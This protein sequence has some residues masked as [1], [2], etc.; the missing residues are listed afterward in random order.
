MGFACIYG[1][2]STGVFITRVKIKQMHMVMRALIDHFVQL[3]ILKATWPIPHCTLNLTFT[4]I[5]LN[6]YVNEETMSVLDLVN[7]FVGIMCPIY[8]MA[9]AHHT[10][11][12]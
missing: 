12:V 8:P 7:D 3:C 2:K 4:A 5:I 10:P 9:W 11:N 6:G 1:L